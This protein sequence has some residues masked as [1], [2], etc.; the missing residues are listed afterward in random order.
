MLI[1]PKSIIRTLGALLFLMGLALIFPALVGW[2]YGEPTWTAFG[3]SAVISAV[4]GAV[5]W[6]VFY[7][8]D[9]ELS[10]REGFAVVA[11]SWVD[12]GP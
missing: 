9:H 5:S 3:W 2:F 7:R 12:R 4:V 1:D 8:E 11:L 10:I 6:L